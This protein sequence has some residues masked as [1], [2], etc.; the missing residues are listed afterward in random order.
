MAL[1]F[2]FLTGSFAFSTAIQ[3]SQN[4][5]TFEKLEGSA[6]KKSMKRCIKSWEEVFGERRK[7]YLW[8]LPVGSFAKI[9]SHDLVKM[10]HQEYIL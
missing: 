9:S 8:L 6:H 4:T 10:T 2:V 5:T 3:F 1:F 7:W